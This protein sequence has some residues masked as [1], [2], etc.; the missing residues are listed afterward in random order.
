MVESD[1]DDSSSPTPDQG[2]ARSQEH[3]SADVVTQYFHLLDGVPPIDQTPE[4]L[5]VTVSDLLELL[6]KA[7]AMDILFHLFCEHDALRFNEIEA[8]TGAS[9]KVLSQRLKEFGD[10]G[11]ITRRSYDEI[12]P[13]VEYEPTRM[14]EELD[15]AFQFLYAWADHHDID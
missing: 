9:P 12:P 15:P 2:G 3:S 1:E 6:T 14:A 13:H 11:L 4:E 7:Y 5:H 10:A 8:A